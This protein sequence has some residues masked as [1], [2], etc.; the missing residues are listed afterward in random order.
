[1]LLTNR[2]EGSTT[3]FG[4][5][6]EAFHPGLHLLTINNTVTTPAKQERQP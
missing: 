6:F 4:S 1:M 2:F 5:Y 3:T